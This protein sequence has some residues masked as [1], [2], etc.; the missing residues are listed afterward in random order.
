MKKNILFISSVL[1]ITLT[2]TSCNDFLNIKP[3][4]EIIPETVEDYEA[5]LNYPDVLKSADS[6]PVFLTDDAYIPETS[7]YPDYFP[8]IRT[9]Q[10]STLAAYTFQKDIFGDANKDYYYTQSYAN[11]YYYNVI[12]SNIMDA[13]DGTDKEKKSIQSEAYLG[14]AFEYLNLV[15]VYAVQ[16]D[17]KTAATDPGVP[18]ILTEDITQ[19]NLTRASVQEVYDQIL[20]DLTEALK[21]LPEKP[22]INAFR[23]SQ[24]VGNGLLARVYL[25][26]G[27]YEKA[28]EY[29]R[30]SLK[31][32]STLLNLLDY[33]VVNPRFAIGRIDVPSRNNN[34]ENI[35]IRL[36]QYVFGN[37]QAVYASQDLMNIFDKENDQRF[38]L[39]YTNEPYG[40]SLDES[41]FIPFIEVN[42][43][44]STAE[45]YLIA[46]EC[47]AR[48]GQVNMALEHLNTLRDH[49]IKNN[50][51][52]T[53]TDKDQVLNEVL[54]ERRREF[55]MIGNYRFIDLRRLNKDPKLAKTVTHIANDKTFTLEP[56]SPRYTLQFPNKVM[57]MNK[58]S[59]VPNP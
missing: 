57:R 3:K 59:L 51:H 39:Y 6:F 27:N 15:N 20:S 34:P 11:I 43:G 47:E 38:I 48:L 33:K 23:G 58:E 56:N 53:L 49:R 5:T 7:K 36:A 26:M 25:Y 35:Y 10:Q 32:N 30:L 4:G 2:L 37:S 28:L 54:K 16:Y 19:T 50:T 24:I 14:R 21:Y 13:I 52:L 45:I 40:I 44:I 12:I 41:L 9:L 8:I 1:W 42:H 17:P 18:L 55:A 46:A 22:K 29:A 31:E